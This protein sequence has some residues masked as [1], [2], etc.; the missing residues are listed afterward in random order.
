MS[1]RIADALTERLERNDAGTAWQMHGRRPWL[2]ASTVPVAGA[3]G[4]P[5][6]SP[7]LTALTGRMLL[8]NALGL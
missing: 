5:P 2:L 8:L 1:D 3:V 6:S 4:R 7:S